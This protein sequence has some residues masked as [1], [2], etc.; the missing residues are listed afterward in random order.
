MSSEDEL[1]AAGEGVEA[2]FMYQYVS[3]AP[4]PGKKHLGIATARIG[5]ASRRRCATT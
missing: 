3:M 5:A 1:T 2:Q 4:P